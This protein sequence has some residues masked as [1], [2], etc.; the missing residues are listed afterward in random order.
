MSDIIEDAGDC[1]CADDSLQLGEMIVIVYT[2]NLI[3][4]TLT[5]FYC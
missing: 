5:C 3:V 2:L 1:S 4:C